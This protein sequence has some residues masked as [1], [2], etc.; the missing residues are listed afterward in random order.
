MFYK[1]LLSVIKSKFFI[2]LIVCSYETVLP[3]ILEEEKNPLHQCSLSAN[4]VV[5][6]TEGKTN[7]RYITIIQT[8]KLYTV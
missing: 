7:N 8:L 6:W 5:I 3:P 4:Y 1:V 2:Y